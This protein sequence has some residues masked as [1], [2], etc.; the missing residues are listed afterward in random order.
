MAAQPTQ[1]GE[2][3]KGSAGTLKEALAEEQE[4]ITGAPAEEPA[5][6]AEPPAAPPTQEI[7]QVAPQAP[8]ADALADKFGGDV[9]KLNA[10]YAELERK[11]SQKAGENPL[12]IRKPTEP[13]LL[14][15][16][17]DFQALA[18]EVIANGELSDESVK[19][20][21]E[22]GLPKDVI[23]QH[24]NGIHAQRE[25]ALQSLNNI[26][27]GPEEFAKIQQWAAV[28]LAE[29]E[30]DIFNEEMQTGRRD[31]MDYAMN[32]LVAR[33]RSTGAGQQSFVEGVAAGIPGGVQ[34]FKNSREMREM[35]A[36]PEYLRGDADAHEKVEQRLAVSDPN[37]L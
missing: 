11:Q 5:A 10:A 6:Q 24:V 32:S 23:Q 7:P 33:Y 19:L 12:L 22:S 18:Q 2:V 1:D 30:L 31:R 28:N 3:Q 25:L 13:T 17:L 16:K 21:A 35:M 36:T 34:P 9:D 4:R 15:D 8:P 29:G 37:L 27:G 26:A 20:V 14:G